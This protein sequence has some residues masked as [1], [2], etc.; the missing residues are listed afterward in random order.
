MSDSEKTKVERLIKDIE[1]VAENQ[2]RRNWVRKSFM[3]P[4]SLAQMIER[5]AHAHKLIEQDV[6]I[7]GDWYFFQHKSERLDRDDSLHLVITACEEQCYKCG[8]N[9]EALTIAQFVKRLGYICEK[10]D[11]TLG[12]KRILRKMEINRELDR[13]HEVLEAKVNDDMDIVEAFEN[14]RTINRLLLEDAL[15]SD[16][17]KRLDKFIQGWGSYTDA[18]GKI[19]LQEFV[20]ELKQRKERHV[21]LKQVRKVLVEKTS[22]AILLGKRRR[23]MQKASLQNADAENGLLEDVESLTKE[24]L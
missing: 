8:G 12:D 1:N 10:C 24:K 2:D 15:T 19:I 20:I 4:P 9:I 11:P 13:K 21:E 16:I 7:T 14:E 5:Y 23:R 17:G 3:Y 6:A 22:D 18:D